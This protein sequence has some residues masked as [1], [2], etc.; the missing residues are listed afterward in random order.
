[1]VNSATDPLT[2]ANGFYAPPN[3]ITNTI[4]VDPNFKIGYAQVWN[5]SV[6]R[7][8]PWSLVM[9][10]TYTGTKG[11]HLLQAFAPNTYPLGAADPCTSCPAGYK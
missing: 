8:L 5:L 3:V 7:D 2:L 6:Q 1:M 9:L 4:A 11:T 10:T